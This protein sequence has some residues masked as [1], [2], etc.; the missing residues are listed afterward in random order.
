MTAVPTPQPSKKYILKT[1]GCKANLYDTQ[2]LEIELQRRGW[3]PATEADREEDVGL[4][5]VNSCTVT[6]E[7][8]KQS[9]K[10]ASRLKKHHPQSKVVFTGCGAEV[11]PEKIAATK[12]VDF[13]VGNQS[14]P[15]LIE[16]VLQ[17]AGEPVAEGRVL[18]K[19]VDYKTL[20]S[21][22]P[23]DREWP[24]PEASFLSQDSLSQGQAVRTR[25]FLKI[26][27]GCNSFCTYCIIP[28][29]RGP[30]R[31]LPIDQLVA[32]V[33]SLAEQGVQEV[34][35][36][37]TNLGDYGS[38]WNKGGKPALEMLVSAVLERTPIR[39]LRVSS[40]DAEEVSDTLLEI[41]RS[42]E[43]FC[44]HIH[45]SLQSSHSR[46]LKLMKRKYD[47]ERVVECLRKIESIQRSAFGGPFVGMDVITG[48]PGETLEEF[49]W[50]VQR[51]RELPWN[52]LHVFP[53]SERSGTPATRLP[54][55]V[56]Q[57][58]RV[59]RSQI[60]LALSLERLKETYSRAL[61]HLKKTEDGVLTEILCETPVQGPDTSKT[62]LAGYSKEYLRVVAPCPP[63]V[64]PESLQNRV[65]QAKVHTLWVERASGEVSFLG[66]W[67]I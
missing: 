4:C 52:R 6:D 36:T 65:I 19:V 37:G 58:E 61:E 59:R 27:E 23:I 1:L 41:M 2:L 31:S 51:L 34:I 8:D 63:G 29:G 60:L 5:L 20:T 55:A 3:S 22:H 38:D 49:E 66:E 21:R 30:S 50:G 53:Y 39:R 46:I 67:I 11:A 40:L 64:S 10:M 42:N 28:Y 45:L 62:W 43:R 25:A 7:A 56:P 48:F 12:G 44:P 16:M 14:K 35:F 26:Q 18:G 9:R 17:A 33:A 57:T 32:Q 47:G 24:E 15:D 13:V 54:S